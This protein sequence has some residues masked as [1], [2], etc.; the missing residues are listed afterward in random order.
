MCGLL[1]L[2]QPACLGL[3]GAVNK[4]GKKDVFS[5]NAVYLLC[6]VINRN[7]FPNNFCM[8]QCNRI[9]QLSLLVP[10]S[11]VYL[12]WMWYNNALPSFMPMDRKPLQ[13][14]YTS[15]LPAFLGFVLRCQRLMRKMVKWSQVRSLVSE[16]T[17]MVC[18]CTARAF[19][20]LQFVPPLGHVQ[21]RSLETCTKNVDVHSRAR[22]QLK[23]PFGCVNYTCCSNWIV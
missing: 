3:Q 10:V 1:M 15:L 14:I 19:V 22:G 12:L 7:E 5:E 20:L 18:S 4:E 6:L 9:A 2:L 8:L 17:V 11:L 23:L 16:L 21:S 13:T